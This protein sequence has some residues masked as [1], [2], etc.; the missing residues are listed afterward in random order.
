MSKIVKSEVNDV[1]RISSREV[2]AMMEIKRHSDLLSKIDKIDKVLTDGK[3]SFVR[4]L[5]RKYI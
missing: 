3:S 4:L 1:V 5:D 2:A